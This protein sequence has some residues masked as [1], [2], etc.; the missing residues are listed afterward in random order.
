MTAQSP[1]YRNDT[2]TLSLRF[3][4]VPDGAPIPDI[5]RD[6]CDPIVLRARFE[7]K[8]RVSTHPQAGPDT[9]PVITSRRPAAPMPD[10]QAVPGLVAGNASAHTE[11]KLIAATGGLIAWG[12]AD[13][14]L[15]EASMLAAAEAA[16]PV[17]LAVGGTMVAFYAVS[18][19]VDYLVQMR[20][21]RNADLPGPLR[22]RS[23]RARASTNAADQVVTDALLP[24]EWSAHH[25]IGVNAAQNHVALLEA[26]ARAGWRMDEPA[27]VIALPRTFAAQE[28]LARAGIHRP[29][30]D[31]GHLK[32]NSDVKMALQEVEQKLSIEHLAPDSEEYAMRAAWLL[33][34][35]QSRL[36]QEALSLSRIMWNDPSRIPVNG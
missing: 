34:E 11:V 1:R 12:T 22:A 36:R 32:W 18:A 6:F 21:D 24:D 27:N 10:R 33:Q 8:P 14:L 26:A 13:A 9:A 23:E 29:V 19:L 3:V 31:N 7:R 16:L 35:S 30:H 4:F 20:G 2:D 5:A 28:K 25:F 17:F 15:A